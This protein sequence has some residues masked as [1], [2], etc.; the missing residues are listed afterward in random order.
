MSEVKCPTMIYYYTVS[1]N[2][3]FPH[4]IQ[5]NNPSS[6]AGNW[7][8]QLCYHVQCENYHQSTGNYVYYFIIMV[9]FYG[10]LSFQR[11][12]V[13]T[14]IFQFS[15]E[16]AKTE[17]ESFRNHGAIFCWIFCIPKLYELHLLFYYYGFILWLSFISKTDDQK[18]LV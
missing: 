9:L 10:Y 15:L 4:F 18:S 5:Q 2:T 12:M 11:P 1:L 6:V 13:N 16:R 7:E 17:N 8:K 14:M 3:P